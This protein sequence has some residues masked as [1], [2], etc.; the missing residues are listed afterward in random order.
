MSQLKVDTITDELGTGAPEFPNGNVGIGTSTNNWSGFRGIQVQQ[1]SLVSNQ[2]SAGNLQTVLG[3]NVFYDGISYKYI[4][5][6]FATYYNQSQ[7]NHIWYTSPTGTSGA[8][9]S[10]TERFRIDN[11]G[12]VTMPGQP[13]FMGV[14]SVDYSSGGMPA[15][16][17]G[18]SAIFNNGGHFNSSNSRFTAPVAGWYQTT[19]GGLQL[20]STVTS[21]MKNGSR[22]RNGNHGVFTGSYITMT[23]T[24]IEY[25]NAGDYLNIEQWNGGGYYSSWYIWTVNLLG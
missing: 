12:R 11:A 8:A 16:I 6:D 20:S 2:F 18:I 7:G 15:G 24:A 13:Y 4:A 17:M 10:P 5:S 3:S 19:W 22:L 23:Q 9:A 1:G 21:L 25:L 14:P